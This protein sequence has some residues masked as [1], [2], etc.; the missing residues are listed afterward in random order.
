MRT[1]LLLV[2]LSLPVAAGTERID[3][4][5]RIQVDVIYKDKNGTQTARKGTVHAFA[6]A[7]FVVCIE[8]KDQVVANCLVIDD[9]GE[10]HWV[11]V[12]LLEEKV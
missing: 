1:F 4:S 8:Y 6:D 11:P 7:R 5:P 10:P 12:R 3:N 9:D 2:L